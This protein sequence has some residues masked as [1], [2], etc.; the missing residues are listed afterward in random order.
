MTTGRV[1]EL[2]E[3]AEDLARIEAAIERGANENRKALDAI[4]KR[5]EDR[6]VT[7]EAYEGH[8]RLMDHRFEA[9][10][11][12][13]GKVEDRHTWLARTAVTA[14]VL[15]ILVLIIGALVLTGGAR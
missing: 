13:V 14:L 11:R 1:P 6:Y 10:D 5:I 4:S 12:Q 8:R 3:L 9:I 2:A 7:K 15:P